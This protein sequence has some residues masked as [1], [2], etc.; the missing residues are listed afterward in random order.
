MNKVLK[1]STE[2]NQIGVRECNIYG[3]HCQADLVILTSIHACQ[4]GA[5]SF[6]IKHAL[7][8]QKEMNIVIGEYSIKHFT[9]KGE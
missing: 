8:L 2:F 5:M 1:V 6:C 9:Q 4:Q 3:C 7:E